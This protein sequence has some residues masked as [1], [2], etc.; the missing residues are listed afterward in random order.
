MKLELVDRRRGKAW[1]PTSEMIKRMEWV[2]YPTGRPEWWIDL[3]LA[4]NSTVSDLNW[5][6]RHQQGVTDVLSF[7]YLEQ[8]GDSAPQLTAGHGY[9]H[10]DLWL[11]PLTSKTKTA[12]GEVVLATGYVADCC[13]EHGWSFENELIFLT[14]HGVLHILGWEHEDASETRAM[15]IKEAELLERAGIEHPLL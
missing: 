6:Y 9:A 8:S 4:D 10:C 7:S 3:V 14:V 12:V 2:C 1:Q 5:R 13:R 15:R 11:D